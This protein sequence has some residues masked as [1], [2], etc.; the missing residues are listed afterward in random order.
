MHLARRFTLAALT[1]LT[2][3]ALPLAAALPARADVITIDPVGQTRCTGSGQCA[4]FRVLTEYDNV[5]HRVRAV[6]TV[7]CFSGSGTHPCTSVS[8]ISVRLHATTPTSDDEIIAHNNG[9]CG[10]S[11]GHSPCPNDII[12]FVTGTAP[13]NVVSR[14]WYSIGHVGQLCYADNNCA[15]SFPDQRNS[16]QVLT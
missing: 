2:A 16:A 10:V 4:A 8:D 9:I 11:V 6:V 7:R 3:V 1:L 5:N 14:A 12:T 15:W 13:T